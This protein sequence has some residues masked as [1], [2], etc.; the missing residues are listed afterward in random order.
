MGLL[1]SD[2]AKKVTEEDIAAVAKYAAPKSLEPR[3]I[4]E[5]KVAKAEP[6]VQPKTIKAVDVTSP[7][8]T[9]DPEKNKPVQEMAAVLAAP[10]SDSEGEKVANADGDVKGPAK[11][12][13]WDTK[14]NIKASIAKIATKNQ[15][16]P[17]AAVVMAAKES[18]LRPNA[19]GE[20]SSA[21]LFGF[22]NATWN[23]QIGKS[24]KKFGISYDTPPTDPYAST[25][26]YTDYM[27][28]NLK[29][30]KS[31]RDNP[32]ITDAYLTH[33]LGPAGAR[34]FLAAAPDE[35]AVNRLPTAA[36]NN[37]DYFYQD[38]KALTIKQV[39]EKIRNSLSKAAREYGVSIDVSKDQFDK[40]DRPETVA[41]SQPAMVKTGAQISDLPGVSETL[42]RRDMLAEQQKRVSPDMQ[43]R[44]ESI[45]RQQARN[46]YGMTSNREAIESSSGRSV[47][48]LVP[49]VKIAD[50][51]LSVT[52]E[53]RDILK[54]IANGLSPDQLK[55]LIGNI[56]VQG[57]E[58][59]PQQPQRP[60]R[61]P[62]QPERPQML[63]TSLDVTRKSR[64]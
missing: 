45:T 56:P 24:G 53:I 27:N 7:K 50:S 51:Q 57:A 59:A 54:E 10:M 9:L 44:Q 4:P 19:R 43:A 13:K 31:V 3:I 23:E 21:G 37:P 20:G 39:Y 2:S 11:D 48:P 34:K 8:P 33:L 32:S 16:D 22:V 6:T 62:Q 52:M 38:G 14:E 5:T 35:Y 55:K 1:N 18:G 63:Q 25:A 64:A 49:L 40:N 36:K 30:I 47:D 58:A 12:L 42:K 15:V 29:S 26:L 28:Q 46:A 61:T 41:S 60:A 17:N